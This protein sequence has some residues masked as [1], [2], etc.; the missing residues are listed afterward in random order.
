ML[1]QSLTA[2]WEPSVARIYGGILGL[3]AFQTTLLRGWMHRN[4]LQSTL[5]SAWLCLM[6][7]TAVGL[8]VG[9]V[10]RQVVIDSVTSQ[11]EGE[12]NMQ[13]EQTKKK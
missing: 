7:F 6:L 3:L 12:L 2:G 10:A 13:E 11:V 4:D 1:L 8:V 5:W 9:R